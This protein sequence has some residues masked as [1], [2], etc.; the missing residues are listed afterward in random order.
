MLIMAAG[1]TKARDIAPG[2]SIFSIV[3]PGPRRRT[4]S[5][6]SPRIRPAWAHNVEVAGRRDEESPGNPGSLL[7]GILGSYPIRYGLIR[8][9]FFSMTWPPNCDHDE[10]GQ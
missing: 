2:A 4:G 5:S 3:Q 6:L 10:P 8:V 1:E 7:S 9:D